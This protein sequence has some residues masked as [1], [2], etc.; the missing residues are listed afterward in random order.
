[1]T[2]KQT[3]IDKMLQF[4]RVVFDKTQRYIEQDNTMS[5]VDRMAI[6]IVVTK[7]VKIALNKG[8]KKKA[9]HKYL[10][11]FYTL[12]SDAV[13]QKLPEEL[14]IAGFFC[15]ALFSNKVF[16]KKAFVRKADKLLDLATPLNLT[17]VEAIV[18]YF[19]GGTEECYI[20]AKE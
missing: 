14:S 5:L 3:V 1:M 2:E 17:N 15:I 20:F 16:T 12:N 6:D 4:S 10:S 8:K 13:F 11:G 18:N 7:D 19:Y 9:I